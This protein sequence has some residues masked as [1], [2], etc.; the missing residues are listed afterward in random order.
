MLEAMT[1]PC[2][3]SLPQRRLCCASPKC[4]IAIHCIANA[5][6]RT[7]PMKSS[8]IPS[9]RVSPELRQAAENVLQEGESLSGFVE[10]SI[11]ANISRR[12][13]QREFLAR[14]LAGRYEA[15]RTGEYF[16]AEVVLH[17]LDDILANAEAK[18][19]A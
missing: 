11:R 5:T 8:S 15:K 17:E 7:F 6:H 9:L 14:G 12:Q 10:Q 4:K 1:N 13:L 18:A 3:R 19:D 16:D 2:G